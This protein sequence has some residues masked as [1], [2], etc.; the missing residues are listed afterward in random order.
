MI[1]TTL[2]N[3]QGKIAKQIIDNIHYDISQGGFDNNTYLITG[4]AGTG[5]SYLAGSI[6]DYFQKNNF[7]IQC[8]ALTHKALK[9][10]RDKLLAQ[11]IN[12]DDLNGI[13]TVHSYFGIKPVIN[14]KT[15]E[16]EFSVN[17]FKKPRKC[18]ILFIDEV[19]MMDLSL[20]KLV[21]SQ[22]H[23]YKTTVL[24]GDEYQISPV[25]KHDKT[26][27][28]FK[29]IKKY[30]LNNIV[31]QAEGNKIIELASEIVQKIKNKDYKDKS[32]CIKKVKEYSKVSDNIDI[33]FNSNDFIKKYWEFTNEDAQKPYFKSKF[34]QALITT[35]TNK[36]V[37]NYNYIAKCIMKQTREINYIDVGDVIVLQSPAFD[38]YLP[39]DIILNN[40]S[41]VI[42][43]SIEEE[44]YEGIPIYEVTVE[45]NLMLRIIKPESTDIYLKELQKYRQAALSNGK[46]W[47]KFY[48]FKN[49]F[50]EIKQAY[51]CTCHK[52]QGSTYERVYVD[53]KDLPWTTDTDLAFRLAYV[54]LTRASDKVIVSTF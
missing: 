30:E 54:G 22:Q 5:K 42:I 45:D 33:V 13:S 25:N 17:Q 9:E 43:N 48:E 8:T 29:S 41:E 20:Y 21:K 14:T 52:A 10:I 38:P 49:K 32:F 24:I 19:S 44:S 15:G 35:F 31:R 6:I 18:D 2:N 11:G 34:S 1:D 46:F 39:D 27:F 28:D 3:E 50:V 7:K 16:E 12:M 26:I 36:V 4:R 47:K 40:N 53:F 51:A 37:D 23:L